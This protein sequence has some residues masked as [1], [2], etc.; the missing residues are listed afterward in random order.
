MPHLS[1]PFMI[2][3]MACMRRIHIITIRYACQG[4]FAVVILPLHTL[5]RTAG[6]IGRYEEVDFNYPIRYLKDWH[7]HSYSPYSTPSTRRLRSS[8]NILIALQFK[9]IYPT[10]IIEQHCFCC[11]P[12]PFDNNCKSRLRFSSRTI[13]RLSCMMQP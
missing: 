13:L 6:L 1:T 10:L 7:L 9:V 2:E 12:S 3:R 11:H 4:V 5:S 8:D